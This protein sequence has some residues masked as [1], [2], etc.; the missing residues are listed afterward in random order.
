MNAILDFLNSHC[1]VRHFTDQPV[2]ADQQRIILTTAQRSP[3]S[4]NL[5]AY[6]TI[7]V[8]DAAKKKQLARLAGDQGHVRECPLFVVFCADLFRLRTIARARGYEFHGEYAEAFIVATVDTALAAGRALMAAQALGLGGV[9]VGGIRNH[10]DAVTKLLHLPDL[11]YPV[12]GMSI[13]WPASPSKIKPRLPAEAVHFSES[14]DAGALARSITAYD[15]VIDRAGHLK[16][17]EIE[18]D[19]YPDFNG[20]YSWSE[21]SARRMASTTETALRPQLLEFLQSRGWLRK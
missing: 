16:G 9:M 7:A 20:P 1:S 14:Y 3:T 13:G 15:S 10:P 12:M 4:S 2:T 17:R 8:R 11:V 19:N 21:H 6:S 5:Q 18:T